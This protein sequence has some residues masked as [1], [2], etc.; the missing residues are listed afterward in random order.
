MI[1]LEKKR[2][3]DSTARRVT[4]IVQLSNHQPCIY[5][6]DELRASVMQRTQD[7]LDGKMELISHEQI[8]KI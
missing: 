8:R 5:T 1:V 3:K 2:Y 6:T 4:K 7:F